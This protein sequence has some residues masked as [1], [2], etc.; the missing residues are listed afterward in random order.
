MKNRLF[1]EKKVGALSVLIFFIC[2]VVLICMKWLPIW[3]SA[4]ASAFIAVTIRQFLAGK[5][6]DII[7]SFVIF[8]LLFIT[9]SYFQSDL[10]TGILIIVGSGYLFIRICMDLYKYHK[11][12]KEEKSHFPDDNDS[13]D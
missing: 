6:I 1:Y 2:M 4:M 11:I 3:A 7:V 5:P 9:N 12:S 13:L 8:G 10:W